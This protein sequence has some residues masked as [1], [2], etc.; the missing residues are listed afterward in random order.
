MPIAL[1]VLNEIQ[2]YERI[3]STDS[4]L[5]KVEGFGGE[6]IIMSRLMTVLRAIPHE[7]VDDLFEDPRFRITLDNYTPGQGRTVLL[8]CPGP[9]GHGSRC[10]VLKRRLGD[11]PLAFAYYVIAHE[12]AH[13]YLRNGAWGDIVDPELAAD[14]LAASWG[15]ERPDPGLS[16]VSISKRQA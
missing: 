5:S 7:V 9:E 15:F 6:Q 3:A 8:S 11:S 14:A 12:L 4:R 10:V 1:P 13:A 2:V 16:D